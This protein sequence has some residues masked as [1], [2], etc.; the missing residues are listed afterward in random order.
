MLRKTTYRRDIRHMLWKSLFYILNWKSSNDGDLNVVEQ[1]EFQIPVNIRKTWL[2]NFPR[3]WILE[4]FA[5]DLTNIPP[6][7][8]EVL[9]RSQQTFQLYAVELH[10]S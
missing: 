5:Q 3:G 7:N 8:F 9:I 4:T 2:T 1:Y 6:S 10:N